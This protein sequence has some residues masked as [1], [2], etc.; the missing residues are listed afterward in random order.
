[1]PS[2]TI[3][4]IAIAIALLIAIVVFSYRQTIYA[5]PKGGGSYIV[6]KDNLGTLPGLV[7]GASLLT[8]YILTVAVSIAAGVANLISLAATMT[9]ATRPGA[10]GSSGALIAILILVLLNL[11]GI[12]EVGHDLLGAD[13][14]LPGADV[15]HARRWACTSISPGLGSLARWQNVPDLAAGGD[16]AVAGWS[17]LFLLLRA[18]ASG[19]AALTGI[20]AISDGVPAFEKPEV[21]N[22]ATTLVILGVLLGMMFLGISFLA[23]HAE[24]QISSTETVVSQLGRTIFG[25][26]PVYTV[27]LIFTA[28]LLVLAAN[29][30]F[31]DFPRLSF[32]L[33]RDRFLPHQ[34][35]FRGD[36]LA[37]SFGIITLGVLAGLLII[38][39]G[40][41]RRRAAAA[42]RHRRVHLV[43]ALAERHGA[44]A[45]GA[46][47][48]PGWHSA[49]PSMP[50]GALTTPWCA[51]I[52]ADHAVRPRAPGL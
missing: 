12:R 5:Y 35:A 20:E 52:L 29:T 1:M 40:G 41:R 38:L 39:F 7:A 4:P 16:R 23:D 43:H 11:R 31:A 3:S 30:A 18:F 47:R 27:F 34:F 22:A 42:L 37:F 13:L 9:W 48:P 32:F 21:K 10:A 28:L 25:P 49:W 8:G 33:A 50:S 51:I 14:Y 26:G 46:L 44:C 6:S 19:C 36:R 45:G 15:R 17:A 2:T 24:V